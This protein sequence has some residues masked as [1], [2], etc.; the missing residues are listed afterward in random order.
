MRQRPGTQLNG[1]SE[2]D[3]TSVQS[4]LISAA[5]IGSEPQQF[6]FADTPESDIQV[7]PAFTGPTYFRTHTCDS[8]EEIFSL[9]LLLLT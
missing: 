4:T 9:L 1:I 2:H 6:A 5:S 7:G 8:G 3:E